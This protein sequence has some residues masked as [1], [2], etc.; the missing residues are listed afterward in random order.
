MNQKREKW[1]NRISFAEIMRIIFL[2]IVVLV[3]LVPFIWAFLSTF[4]TNKEI[5]SSAFSMPEV[6]SI[7]NYIDVLQ[8]TPMLLFYMN[9]LI[10]SLASTL[11]CLLIFGMA[12]Y[13]LARF[14]FK[15]RGIIFGILTL[16]MLVPVTAIIFPVYRLMN[17]LGLY[18][19]RLGLILVYT[20]ISM[21]VS[22]YILRSFFMTIPKELEEAAYIDG[23]SFLRTYFTVIV[24]IAKPGFAAAA[25]L[26][27]LTAWNDFFYAYILTSGTGSRT[28]PVAI[29]HFQSEYATNYGRMFATIILIVIPTVLIY[30][31]LHKKIEEGL[32]AGSVKG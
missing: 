17:N 2:I 3:S 21:P 20:A 11:V 9:S 14:K 30:L 18:D 10:V 22:L 6:W 23:A 31:A 5:L 16:S 15:G 19:T 27:F 29:K 28:V 25:V 24:P 32:V 13:A 8:E 4:K 26:A 7:K 12:A 1:F